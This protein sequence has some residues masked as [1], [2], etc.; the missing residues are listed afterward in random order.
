VILLETAAPLGGFL[1]RA[2]DRNQASVRLVEARGIRFNTADV[3][4]VG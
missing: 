2:S 3:L 4:G 1:L